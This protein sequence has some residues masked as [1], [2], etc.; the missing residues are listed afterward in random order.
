MFNTV[1]YVNIV[2][3]CGNNFKILPFSSSFLIWE[4]KISSKSTDELWRKGSRRSINPWLFFPS[5]SFF[6]FF[7]R[8]WVKMDM[9]DFLKRESKIFIRFSNHLSFDSLCCKGTKRY[10]RQ[11][12][13]LM[14]FVW[15]WV[16]H[17]SWA[18]VS[19]TIKLE[20]RT[21]LIQIIAKSSKSTILFSPNRFQTII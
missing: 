8:K 17:F 14:S 9:G 20:Y 1:Q 7:L 4:L 21:R 13:D 19:S 15:S 5:S 6:F 11:R 16:S 3:R 2:V 12:P 10:V 18:S